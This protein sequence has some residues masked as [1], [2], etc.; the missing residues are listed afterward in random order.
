[1]SESS[2][3]QFFRTTTGI[4]SG[5]DNLNESRVIMTFLTI[6]RVTEMLCTFRLVVEGKTAKEIPESS[7]L[8]FLE[9]SLANNC[10]IRC[11]RQHLGAVEQRYSRFIFVEKT[12]TNLPNVPQPSFW[13]VID[14]FVLV[15]YAGL[16]A[17]GTLL[18]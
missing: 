15:A 17:S 14:S 9:K 5:P 4:Q 16:A 6:L 11:R 1:M 18:Q 2:V 7:K 10:F 12:I 3:S 13:E 8:E